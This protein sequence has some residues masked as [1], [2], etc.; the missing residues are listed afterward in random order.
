MRGP[1]PHCHAGMDKIYERAST[2]MKLQINGK[3]SEFAAE[4][5]GSFT[6]AALVES[7]DMKPERVAVELN[8]NV[9]PRELWGQTLLSDGDR[10]EVVHFVGG[11]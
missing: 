6:L 7:L 9:V 3:E 10:L 2:A 4:S 11:G 8:R 1:R 5:G